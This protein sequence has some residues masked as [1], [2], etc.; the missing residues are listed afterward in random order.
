MWNLQSSRRFVPSSSED[1]VSPRYSGHGGAGSSHE[2]WRCEE[3]GTTDHWHY[4]L[5]CY[6]WLHSIQALSRTCWPHWPRLCIF[7]RKFVLGSLMP[8]KSWTMCSC[9]APIKLKSADYYIIHTL[10]STVFERFLHGR[11][12]TTASWCWSP[13]DDQHLTCLLSRWA[14]SLQPSYVLPSVCPCKQS[15]SCFCSI[16]SI[17]KI[18]EVE[19]MNVTSFNKLYYWIPLSD[20]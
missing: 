7:C 9:V 8:A 3:V 12:E 15:W 1:W 18:L 20:I 16:E 14:C 19:Q 6:N 5:S 4:T 10:E 17:L 11:L 2:C 13:V